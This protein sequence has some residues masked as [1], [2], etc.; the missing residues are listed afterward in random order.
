MTGRA[1]G[2]SFRDPSGTVY[3]SGGTLY[4]EI[5]RRYAP[6]WD[7]LL[8]SGLY[9]ELVERE[10][11]VPHQEVDP[12][13]GLTSNAWKV[14]RPETVPFVSYPW[15][16]CFG[17]LK[18]AAL[19]TLDIQ[20]LSLARGLSLKDASA[21]NVQFRRSRP[22]LI[23]TLSFEKHEAGA[24]WVAY[25]QFCRHFLAPLLLMSRIDPRLGLLSREHP[26]GVPLDLAS[27]LLPW[28][29]RFRPG[30]WAAA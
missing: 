1:V 9:D 4:R 21:F 25:Q 5:S 11:L 14:I 24:P 15:E 23:D 13:L 29:S 30:A 27:E 7:L 3:R 26:D 19:L 18:S 20:R 8:G 16:W 28:A 2:G 10:M 17:Q 6:D 22:L 12:G